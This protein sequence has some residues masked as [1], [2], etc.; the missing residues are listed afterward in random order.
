MAAVGEITDVLRPQEARLRVNIVLCIE[1]GN[2]RA[3]A[4]APHPTELPCPAAP[5]GPKVDGSPRQSR[6][7]GEGRLRAAAWALFGTQELPCLVPLLPACIQR[8][9][10]RKNS[11]SPSHV[12]PKPWLPLAARRCVDLQTRP[13]L[14]AGCLRSCRGS[15]LCS[16]REIPTICRARGAEGEFPVRV[17]VLQH[18]LLAQCCSHGSLG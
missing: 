10:G 1:V 3:L 15:L 12:P 11:C 4:A 18:P 8:R 16:K 2:P 14:P 13:A 9:P 6:V 7:S 17:A 5:H